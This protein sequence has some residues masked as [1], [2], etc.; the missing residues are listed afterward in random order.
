[1]PWEVEFTAEFGT[2]WDQLVEAEQIKVAAVVRLLEELGPDLPF[3]ISSGVKG[4]RFARLRELRIQAV[5]NPLRVLYAFDPRRVAILLLG[6]NKKGHD[7]W[8]EINLAKADKL[9]S[10]H[11]QLL[12]KE[13]KRRASRG[14]PENG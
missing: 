8:Y 10:Q 9:F 3:P 6:G 1:V 5:G 11:L 13:A 14:D 7:R 4:S 12:R 2:W